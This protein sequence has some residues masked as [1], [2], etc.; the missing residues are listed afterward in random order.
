MVFPH[1]K[2][3]VYGLFCNM[4]TGFSKGQAME[5]L[6]AQIMVVDDD[7]SICQLLSEL[8]EHEGFTP[9]MANDG[10]TALELMHTQEPDVI[11]LD[12]K[13][14]RLDGAEVLNKVKETFA[15]LPVVIITAYGE[16]Q[17]AVDAIKSGAYDYLTKPFNHE[18]VIRVVYKALSERSLKRKLKNLTSQFRKNNPLRE[19]MGP[20]E[21]VGN[22]ITAV[23][24]VA[25][26]N[27]T[28]V[29]QGET[30][31]GKDVVAQAI[32]NASNRSNGPFVSLDCGAI[33]ETL[34]ESELFGHEKG[35]FTGAV[36]KFQG[37]FVSANGGTLLL[38]EIA[39]LPLAS[40][41]KL[42][43]A[44][45]E[46]KVLPVGASKAE[47]VNVRL[48]TAANQNL[49]QLTQDGCFRSDLYFRL[50]EFTINIPP[51]RERKDDILY[52]AKRFLDITCMELEKEIKGF[53]E[54]ALEM[55]LSYNW[56]GNVRELRSTVRRAVL[57]AEDIVTRE[58]LD[59]R[60]R[61]EPDQNPVAAPPVPKPEPNQ[62][63][64]A[65]VQKST[66]VVEREVLKRTLETTNGN[67]AKAARMLQIDYKTMLTKIKK[68]GI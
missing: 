21:A 31:S 42:L 66:A 1:R 58:D 10:E 44:V 62:S 39:N 11:L 40:Q 14:P 33:P 57:M 9:I 6:S 25:H 12:L 15:D 65:I 51:L 32:H 68:F 8:M 60:R 55:L 52:L 67:K 30:G 46:K 50:K 16:I 28:V 63:L 54:Q 17:G 24:Q 41:A 64:R 26:T 20:S 48:L 37:K 27:F 18:D 36:N 56:P 34:L 49:H 53:S 19:I 29:I 13:M 22:I 5:R 38:D 23:E 47:P 35:A 43:R 3:A 7:E 61:L 4:R 45:Q 2:Q 59:I